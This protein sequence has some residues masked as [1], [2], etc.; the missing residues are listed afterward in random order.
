MKDA[1]SAIVGEIAKYLQNEIPG[2][3]EIHEEFPAANRELEKPIAALTTVSNPL[4]PMYNAIIR[5]E[6]DPQ[7]ANKLKTLSRVGQYNYRL[8]LDIWAETKKQRN[9][10]YDRV[11]HAMN[12]E[13]FESDLG[14][15]VSLTLADYYDIIARYEM[16]DYTF[17]DS[18]QSSQTDEWRVKITIE[19]NCYAVLEKCEP[20]MKEI[21]VEQTL[22]HSDTEN[23]TDTYSVG[24]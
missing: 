2:L 12:K 22:E 21:T 8:Q 17:N 16:V 7:N 9:E 18:E 1:L 23:S 4:T 19:G 20:I 10:L 3:N 14:G 13:A 24:E 6:A 15:G 11:F 5:T